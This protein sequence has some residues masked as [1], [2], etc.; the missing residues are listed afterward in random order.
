MELV[1]E[2][3][4]H[5]VELLVAEVLNG[6]LNVSRWVPASFTCRQGVTLL[7]LRVAGTDDAAGDL[8]IPPAVTPAPNHPLARNPRN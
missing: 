4:R 2:Q 3:L 7:P 8:L 6:L 5:E 1:E